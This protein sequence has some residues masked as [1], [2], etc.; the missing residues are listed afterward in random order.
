MSGNWFMVH[1][2]GGELALVAVGP[3]NGCTRKVEAPEIAELKCLD[4]S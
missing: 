4:I 2:P 1:W 3:S